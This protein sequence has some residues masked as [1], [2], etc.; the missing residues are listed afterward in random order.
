MWEIRQGPSGASFVVRCDDGGR[1]QW[2]SAWPTLAG[3]HA[4]LRSMIQWTEGTPLSDDDDDQLD[5]SAAPALPA[6][7]VEET[8]RSVWSVLRDGDARQLV[9]IESQWVSHDAALARCVWLSECEVCHIEGYA[10]PS[11]AEWLQE[12][13]DASATRPS[14][15]PDEIPY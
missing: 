11:W 2:D 7:R 1:W 13:I 4:R 9:T 8:G 10:P 3:A 14:P 15:G 12:Y 5:L 6:W